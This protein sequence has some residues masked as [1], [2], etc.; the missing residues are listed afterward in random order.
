MLKDQ[1]A[2]KEQVSKCMTTVKRQI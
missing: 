1:K 2:E